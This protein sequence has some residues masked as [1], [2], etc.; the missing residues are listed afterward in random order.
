MLDPFD[1]LPFRFLRPADRE[2]VREHLHTVHV[3]LGTR[4]LT[5]DDEG[6]DT[7]WLLLRGEVEVI[8]RRRGTEHLIG[9]IDAGHYFGERR[10]LFGMPRA[11]DI[12]ARTDCSAALFPGA[13]LRL[14]AN[15]TPVFAH[16]MARL[17]RDKQ[18]LFAAF[19]RFLSEIEHG[20]AEGYLVIEKLLKRY[21]PLCPALHGGASSRELDL[22]AMSYAVRRLPEGIEHTLAL[23]LTDELPATIPEPD[24]VFRAVPTA[25]RRRAVYE[26]L[27][28]KLLVVL[29]DGRSDLN[30]LICCLC[31]FAIESKKLRQRIQAAGGLAILTEQP[32]ILP[33]NGEEL[34]RLEALWPGRVPKVLLDLGSLHEDFAI[35]LSKRLNN[36]NVAHGERWTRQVHAA[37]HDLMGMAPED[38]PADLPVHIVSSNTHSVGNCL[39]PWLCEHADTIRAWGE[40]THPHL[41]AA[42]WNDPADL[43]VALSRPF[44]EAHPELAAER[45]LADCHEAASFLDDTAYTGI[46]VQLYDL[47]RLPAGRDPDL[48][49][50][51]SPGLLVNIDYAFGEQAEAILARLIALFGHNIRSI[52]VLGKAGGLLG[53]RGDVMVA[54]R[55]VEQRGDTL[56]PLPRSDDDIEALRQR[57]PDRRVHVG[58]VLTVVGTILQNRSMLQTYRHL[59]R[60]VGVEMEGTW[61][62]QQI[63]EA[64]VLGLLPPDID[65]HFWYYI[66][67]LPLEAEHTLTGVLGAHEGIPPLYAITRQVLT[68]ILST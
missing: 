67:D 63:A 64:Q 15:R 20:A 54:T 21:R 46:K 51:N 13:S 42:P 56:I 33:F 29:R 36:Y 59:F 7:V 43:V 47:A 65:L 18:G 38:M 2:W 60:C 40:T 23:F 48:P 68:R 34:A 61:Y 27:P 4:I 25:S 8:D 66:S 26:M 41:C 30:D 57:L 45:A 14:L 35:H 22:D 24:K 53:R 44:L 17:L 49:R 5:Q 58:P 16:A 32:P 55:F 62:A 1:I 10:A 3:P 39:S 9:V 50:E 28:G 37:T 12:V 52:H 19:E 6:D 11:A 31:I